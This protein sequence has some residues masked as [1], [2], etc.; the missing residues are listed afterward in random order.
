M[1][2][3][4]VNKVKRQFKKLYLIYSFV[5]NNKIVNQKTRFGINDYIK[6]HRWI[7]PLIIAG[8]SLVLFHMSHFIFTDNK[9]L[10]YLAF[11]ISYNYED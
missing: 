8:W 3:R 9:S 2:S 4:E 6:K 1:A 10:I 5:L 11:S 7:Y